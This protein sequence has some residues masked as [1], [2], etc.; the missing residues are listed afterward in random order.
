MDKQLHRADAVG[1]I[2]N[3]RGGNEL[4]TQRLTEEKG[5]T[6]AFIERAVREIPQRRLTTPGFIDPEHGCLLADIQQRQEG[7]VRAPG[8][9]TTLEDMAAPQDLTEIVRRMGLQGGLEKR[10]RTGKAFFCHC[11]DSYGTAA[12]AS[13]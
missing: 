2:A 13:A 4:P 1:T 7:V 9:E 6:L 12:S 11:C 10:S 5:G 8:D 3:H